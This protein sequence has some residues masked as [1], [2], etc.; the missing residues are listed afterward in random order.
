ME[1]LKSREVKLFSQVADTIAKPKAKPKACTFH[2]FCHP[3][4]LKEIGSLKQSNL[5][6]TE[7]STKL[8]KSVHFL[9]INSVVLWI[10]T[11]PIFKGR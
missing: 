4:F 11:Q 1:I 7:Y 6:S 2:P 9:S 8:S 3:T 5:I 10:K